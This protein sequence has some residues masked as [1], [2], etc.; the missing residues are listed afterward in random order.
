MARS[1]SKEMR[2]A[3]REIHRISDALVN[4]KLA[5]GNYLILIFLCLSSL[6]GDKKYIF[7]DE[8]RYMGGRTASFLRDI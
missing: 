4:A 5:F 2:L 8:Q 1:L 7:S 3:T 6:F